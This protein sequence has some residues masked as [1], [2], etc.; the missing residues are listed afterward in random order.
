M[1]IQITTEQFFKQY[2]PIQNHLVKDTSWD[3]CMFETDGA[4]LQFV[5]QQDPNHIWTIIDGEDD[6]EITNGFF[7]INRIGYIITEVASPDDFVVVRDNEEEPSLEQ[8]RD[9]II[10]DAF[11]TCLNDSG[12]LKSI[13]QDYFSDMD[14]KTTRNNYYE[15]LAGA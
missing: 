5:L 8:M 3:G 9:A 13:L 7:Q 15:M 12:Y 1:T 14:E 6:L 4:E 2:K 11:D 10:E